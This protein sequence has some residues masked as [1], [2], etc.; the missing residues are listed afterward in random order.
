M[1]AAKRVMLC[2]IGNTDLKAAAGNIAVGLGPIAQA[3][4]SLQFEEI[5]LISNFPQVQAAAYKEWLQPRSTGFITVHERKLSGPTEF[6]EIYEA[7]V[8]VIEAVQS[9]GK[10]DIRLTYHL[11]PGTPAMAAVW[12]LLAKTRFP[13]ELIESS[14]A[15]GV[16]KVTI[17]F[18]ISVDFLPD[19]SQKPDEQL[20]RLMQGLSPAAPEF[21]AII[22]RSSV[23][24]RVVA[25][26]RRVA[27][28]SVPVLI[29]GES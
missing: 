12:L 3:V 22:H 10:R 5:H 2:W 24:K 26:A 14:Q 17:P 27:L 4:E 13:A 9:K 28:R 15:A 6:G 21:E 23:M 18:D 29:E 20:E 25:K 16:R 19:L 11:S 1:P 7:V 8:S